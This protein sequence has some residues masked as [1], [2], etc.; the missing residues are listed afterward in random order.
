[1]ERLQNREDLMK[2]LHFITL[3]LILTG[4]LL[5]AG[6]IGYT[7][8]EPN[9]EPV[10]DYVEFSDYKSDYF[11]NL[12]VDYHTERITEDNQEYWFIYVDTMNGRKVIEY[13][14]TVIDGEFSSAWQWKES[15]I[16][17]FRGIK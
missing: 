6:Y 10:R 14:D 4:L 5:A 11:F 7:M 17:N 2:Q 15:F 8:N 13:S 9:I 12:P 16:D 3:S 1:M